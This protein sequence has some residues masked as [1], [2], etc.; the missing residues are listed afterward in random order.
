M[1]EEHRAQLTL[2]YLAVSEMEVRAVGGLDRAGRI[3]RQGERR[4]VGILWIC[5]LL[6]RTF[7]SLLLS[8]SISPRTY[9]TCYAVVPT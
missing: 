2:A 6:L 3:C 7:P 9:S 1:E 5:A 8:P 4:G